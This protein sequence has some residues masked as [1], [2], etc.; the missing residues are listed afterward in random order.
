MKYIISDIHGDLVLFKKM[1]RKINFNFDYD[2]L[3]INGDIFDRNPYGIQV[4]QFIKPF[5]EAGTM[6]MILGNHELFALRYM[7]GSL[8]E[9]KWISFG[10]EDTLKAIKELSEEE[11]IEL[12]T[13]LLELP[14]YTEID[15]PKFGRTV[16]T[17]TGIS[18]A[19][20]V[21]NED[22][23]INVTRSIDKAAEKNLMEYLISIDI[24]YVPHQIRKSFDRFLVV[25]HVCTFGLNEDA[26][27]RI[28]RTSQYIN[29]DCGAGHRDLG[30][31]LGCYCVDTDEE[32]YVSH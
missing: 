8:S 24:H 1:L 4:Y 5:V 21:Y 20:Y 10:G 29:L 30:G 11:R 26:S 31:I 12:L 19:I 32:F 14:L 22:G 17:H 27:N 7:Q 13:F 3:I 23:T 9:K 25:G 6:Q 15:T 18:A 28:Y 2:E 16:I